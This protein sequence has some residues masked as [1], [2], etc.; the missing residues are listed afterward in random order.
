VA[1]GG[2]GCT[3]PRRG[4]ATQPA[5]GLSDRSRPAG[6]PATATV[7][8][9]KMGPLADLPAPS[10]L[11][12][13]TI[14][15]EALKQYLAGLA[16]ARDYQDSDAI[17]AFEAALAADPAAFE[18]RLSLGR[19]ALRAG[20]LAKAQAALEVAVKQRP[21]SREVHYLL[22]LV[23]LARNDGLAALG[24]L[25]YALALAAD[26]GERAGVYFYLAQ[27]L[28]RQNYWMAAVE[29]ARR[30]EV[31]AQ[32]AADLPMQPDVREMVTSQAW[33]I[34]ALRGACLRRLGR[35]DQAVEAYQAA[36]RL[37]PGRAD[38]MLRLADTYIDIGDNR[39]AADIAEKVLA[40]APDSA[41]AL[42]M[43]AATLMIDKR[44]ADLRQRL[45]AR[46][47]ENSSDR[48]LA[49]RVAAI[50]MKFGQI[51]PALQALLIV[52]KAN[53][54]SGPIYAAMM[55]IVLSCDD[56]RMAVGGLAGVLAQIEP[57]E[58]D[59]LLASLDVVH[60]S[61]NLAR[62]MA[63]RGQTVLDAAGSDGSLLFALGILAGAADQH[64]LS[65][66]ALRAAF[67][68]RPDSLLV[69]TL[70]GGELLAQARW[71]DA[72]DFAEPLAGKFQDAGDLYRIV[73]AGYDGLD[74]YK[75]A[76]AS[77]YEAL[78]RDK[79]DFRAMWLAAQ[80]N[81]RLGQAQPAS[82]I[83]QVLV[84]IKPDAWP[85]H[86][87]LVKDLLALR[88]KD[89]AQEHVK[90][91]KE[92]FPTAPAT[93]LCRLIV[94]A[95][96]TV[97]PSQKI[98]PLIKDHPDDPILAQALGESLLA[99]GDA[100]AAVTVLG[101][102]LTDDPRNEDVRLLLTTALSRQLHTDLAM[103]VL[104]SLLAE[105]PNRVVWRFAKAELLAQ[106]GDPQAAA[107]VMFSLLKTP[108]G[109]DQRH[110]LE[111]R[112]VFFLQ[113][114]GR[115]QQAIDFLDEELKTAPQ[116]RTVQALLLG[117]LE[118][119][120]RRAEA[121]DRLDAW[122]AQAPSDA[123]LRRLEV[124]FLHAADQYEAAAA[125]A[126]SDWP[127]GKEDSA[128]RTSS[129]D[130][131]LLAA[132]L[133]PAQVSDWLLAR[134]WHGQTD[135]V[136]RSLAEMAADRG[137]YVEAIELG[138]LTTRDEE[139]LARWTQWSFLAGDRAQAEL[140][141]LPQVR[142]KNA[143]FYDRLARLLSTFYRRMGLNEL[144]F[145]QTQA[146]YRQNGDADRAAEYANDLGYVLAERQQD[147]AVAEDLA[148]QAVAA[149]PNSAAY[150]DT[151]GWVCYQQGRFR[152]ARHWIQQAL[153]VPGQG[154]D[155]VLREHMGDVCWRLGDHAEAVNHW[156]KALGLY[157]EQLKT[158]RLRAD[159]RQ[160]LEAVSAKVQ[161]AASHRQPAVAPWAGQ[162]N[163]S[164]S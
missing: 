128:G 113:Y 123:G 135:M 100:R 112:L 34:V 124:H 157:R 126:L 129:Q 155:A 81:D 26:D 37:A 27:V 12:D 35:A 93:A 146:M 121:M 89:A 65:E 108:W 31:M 149:D 58:Q 133:D 39:S 127:G 43:L 24:Q 94:E 91:M 59:D 143:D 117:V 70:L 53:D 109:K 76:M 38:V 18:P 8:F 57:A 74:E 67:Q 115:H 5:V 134:S 119:Q 147:L 52:R 161:A 153:R 69:A 30:F 60:V 50:F 78:R 110:V 154:E 152:E 106:T 33:Q 83:Y 97:P 42:A 150:M 125:G 11:Q 158:D 7:H 151:L 84:A 64:V 141:L 10:E 148:R 25:R 2:A 85:A 159:L 164:P 36:L 17:P 101:D 116:D 20:D 41:D 90:Q 66:K 71:K 162:K 118:N 96:D 160:G 44:E 45:L 92:A 140:V 4:P 82:S 6:L 156:R 21:R 40:R 73:G 139:S 63:V 75:S 111:G 49:Q 19:A 32:A 145:Q 142:S 114:A 61:A 62:D 9:D 79:K 131:L 98:A 80:I 136:A 103:Q 88:Q 87:A 28:E 15:P 95:G 105:H 54:D 68:T 86:L 130:L 132:A 16:L 48:L 51:D 1:V 107:E 99:E 163:R 14:P 56:V 29:I 144:S 72:I 138:R 104:D 55:Q 46:V 3:V 77:L 13:R 137:E 122:R 22:G 120:G 102:L 47:Q 23:A